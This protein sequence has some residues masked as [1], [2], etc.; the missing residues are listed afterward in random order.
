MTTMVSFPEISISPELPPV[1]ILGRQPFRYQQKV[2]DW[3]IEKIEAGQTS[4]PEFVEMRLGKTLITINLL[5]YLQLKK[6]VKRTLIVCPKTVIPVWERELALEGLTALQFN[7][8]VV[9]TPLAAAFKFPGNFVTNYECITATDISDPEKYKW[10]CVILDET[11]KIRYPDTQIT[12]KIIADFKDVP[13]KFALTGSPD[14]EGLLDYFCQMKFLFGEV[15][16]IDSHWKFKDRFFH[17]AGANKWHPMRGFQDLF[18]KYLSDVAYVLTREQCDMGSHKVYQ[19]RYVEMDQEALKFYKEF[20]L[21]WLN[22]EFETQWAIVAF[23]YM[24]QMA[25]G[26]PKGKEFT[27][28]HK[29]EEVWDIMNNDLKHEKVVIWCRYR[30]EIDEVLRRLKFKYVTEKIDGSIPN[31]ERANICHKFQNGK[32][33]NCQVLVAQ[34]KTASMGVDFSASD[35]AIYYSNGLGALD[36]IQSEDRVIHPNKKSP[37]LFIDILTENTIDIDVYERYQ[38]KKLGREN[39]LQDIFKNMRS[40]ALS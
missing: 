31:E 9:R 39:F 1:E 21:Q 24:Q 33:E 3:G 12:K 4:I 34:I 26:F 30:N 16:G 20:E 5:K 28:N 10:D 17:S 40:R 27:S 22:K 15:F 7:T 8:K 37:V 19:Q 2:I 38:Q 11:T 35:T 23:N 13:Y 18:S 6:N 32:L 36:R 25:G 14:P 29:V